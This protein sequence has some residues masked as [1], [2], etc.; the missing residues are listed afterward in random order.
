MRSSLFITF[1]VVHWFCILTSTN[2]V[3]SC[4]SSAATGGVPRLLMHERALVELAT[5]TRY[6]YG[7]FDNEATFSLG[8]P[9]HLPYLVLEQDLQAMVRL[10]DF[11]EPFVRLPIRIQKSSIRTGSNIA[12]TSFG[13]RMPIVKENFVSHLPG[14]TLI[15]IIKAPTGVS[16]IK[17]ALHNENITS[18]GKWLVTF[19]LMLEKEISR[20]NYGLGYSFS[21]EPDYFKTLKV[22]PGGI[23]SPS[24]TMGFALHDNGFLTLALAA[25]FHGPL[26]INSH[27][28]EDSDQRKLTISATYGL[29][30]HSHVK[31]NV[32][33]GSDVPISYLG[34]SFNNE[35]YIRLS[36]RL[37]VF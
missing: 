15:S 26:Q 27:P 8:M 31:I 13:A 7:S 34:K 37:G 24:L 22:K 5:S 6:I 9:G 10:W 18:M 12:D 19:G 30:L 17:Q 35:L 29:N 28:E 3:A 11:F 2:V 32:Q 36:M 25:V 21:F 1:W 23:H 33:L 4:C 16:D 20:I 14:L